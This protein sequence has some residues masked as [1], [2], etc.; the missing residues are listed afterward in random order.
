MKTHCDES[1]AQCQV[2]RPAN[3]YEKLSDKASLQ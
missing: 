1:I 3:R 2:V